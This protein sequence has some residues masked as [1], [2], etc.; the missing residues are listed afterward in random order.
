MIA[1]L[2]EQ[3]V[4][5][6][7]SAL[8]QE[9]DGQRR[10]L[11]TELLATAASNNPAALDPYLS[12]QPWYVLRNLATVLGRTG[13]AAAIAGTR[14]LLNHEDHRVR[15]EATRSLA[16]LAGDTA[17]PT[18]VRLLGDAHERVR[19]T[20]VSLTRSIGGE[21]VDRL[22]ISEIENRR[23]GAD[24]AQIVIRILGSRNSTQAVPLLKRFA[25]KRFVWGARR[26]IR[27][28]AREALERMA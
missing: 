4:V 11:L 7:V 8:S 23:L 22:L 24:E 12:N 28:A 19:Q 1:V 17:A 10:R 3:L 5:P 26:H 15:V 25:A 18:L 2:G 21:E 16:R 13:K 6:L 27:A 14:R 9:E 20:A